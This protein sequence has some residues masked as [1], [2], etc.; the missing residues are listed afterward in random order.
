MK[1]MI[2]FLLSFMM[3]STV[4]A[5]ASVF[6]ETYTG[7]GFVTYYDNFE[8]NLSGD[9]SIDNYPNNTYTSD[10]FS[11]INGNNKNI[12]LDKDGGKN[13]SVG[14]Q[15]SVTTGENHNLIGSREIP[16]KVDG[17][18]L[19][20]AEYD[21]KIN[22]F[23]SEYNDASQKFL[24]FGLDN[25]GNWRYT[26]FTLCE[27][28]VGTETKHAI[29]RSDGGGSTLG[30]WEAGKWYHMIIT[31]GGGSA[32]NTG[33]LYGEDGNII[34]SY[35]N[36]S[37]KND[38]TD[39]DGL[40]D[41]KFSLMPAKLY[42]K[43]PGTS[44]TVDNV[45]ITEYE[46]KT[47]APTLVNPPTIGTIDPENG[48]NTKVT[49][50]QP[51]K[52]A[53]AKLYL[54]SADSDPITCTMTK[55]ANTMSTYTVSYVG[56]LESEKEYILDF[57]GTVNSMDKASGDK[58][59]FSTDVAGIYN[60]TDS[61]EDTTLFS[62]N[63]YDGGTPAQKLFGAKKWT[64]TEGNISSAENGYS[65]KGL[66]LISKKSSSNNGTQVMIK[67]HEAITVGTNETAIVTYRLKFENGD[68]INSAIYA[69]ETGS[70]TW[71]QLI[72]VFRNDDNGNILVDY[73]SA[74]DSTSA[75]IDTGKWYNVVFVLNN[76]SEEIYFIDT[77]TGKIAWNGMIYTDGTSN[78]GKGT[79]TEFDVN[80]KYM[81]C[82][83]YM[84]QNSG[85]GDTPS[86]RAV[87]MDDLTM[88]K[89]QTNVESNKLKLTN[90]PETS[91]SKDGKITMT[92]NQPIVDNAKAFK[93]YKGNSTNDIAY[94][95]ANVKHTDFCTQEI[96]FSNLYSA[97]EYTLDYSG[98][99]GASNAGFGDAAV[100]SL[101]QFSTAAPANDLEI[102]SEIDVNGL[103]SGST[104]SVS[105]YSD[106][107]K[108]QNF[109]VAVYERGISGKLVGVL[110]EEKS[111]NIGKNDLTFTLNDDYTDAGKVKIMAFDF[112]TMN[113]KM[114]AGVDEVQGDMDVLMIGNS[115]SEDANRNLYQMLTSAGIA[116]SNVKLTV[117]MIGGSSLA[118][119]YNNLYEEIENDRSVEEAKQESETLSEN[120][121]LPRLLY[122][123]SQ[124][125]D[126][127][128]SN[129][130]I[131]DVL[132]EKQYDVISLQPFG[133]DYYNSESTSNLSYLYNKIRELQPNADIMIYQTWSPYSSSQLTRNDTFSMQM[134]PKI[135]SLAATQNLGII[136]SGKAFF[137]ADNMNPVYGA[138]YYGSDGNTDPGLQ[139]ETADKLNGSTGLWRDYNHASYYGIYLTDAVWFETLTGMLAPIGTEASPVI[140]K[141]EDVSASEHINRLKE[142]RDI[143][144]QV[145][146]EQKSK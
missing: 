79:V 106:E 31:R 97:N 34:T 131:L 136:P 3:L 63:G 61:F 98:M 110:T 114:P 77:T 51:V 93:V 135:A 85:L 33:Y 116:S 72:A 70:G 120:G 84:I 29:R 50:N 121:E 37:G 123:V 26:C 96:S 56:E 25:D 18:N 140:G 92:F 64:Y 78:E 19:V 6:A 38:D 2:S 125:G 58:I 15:L 89:V 54:K 109:I 13:G 137:M 128:T 36:T 10:V 102:V 117:A 46:L 126:S 87:I 76:A 142:L 73:P 81:V 82:P 7:T 103:T 115:L 45:S 75:K 134:E 68:K 30:Y 8:F 59:E 144:H 80:G 24:S 4:F 67:Q 14:L 113:P 145:A 74:S 1:K 66:K 100:S 90:T 32:N 119:H 86:T 47:A 146:R 57:T 22:S 60:F 104:V 17:S 12:I 138:R 53:S 40:Y 111:L 65:G 91:I 88:W 124:N 105:V 28:G 71:N 130:R 83:F 139:L 35:T 9:V 99:K 108:T 27:E 42:N 20:V 16:I 101:L 52:T 49:F 133:D 11:Q 122:F 62:G 21:F 107:T 43:Y 48:I 44:I 55:V 129:N 141:P 112:T 127:Y 41:T 5:N 143:A 39:G 95:T 132:R 94:S 23:P 118:D 69:N